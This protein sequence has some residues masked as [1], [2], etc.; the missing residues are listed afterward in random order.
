MQL[1]NRIEE[2]KNH[3][4]HAK[5]SSAGDRLVFLS[6]K[7]NLSKF[8]SSKCLANLF[9]VLHWNWLDFSFNLLRMLSALLRSVHRVFF[10]LSSSLEYIFCSPFRSLAR[11]LRFFSRFCIGTT[12]KSS[13]I[14]LIINVD[15]VC[16]CMHICDNFYFVVHHFTSRH[17][18]QWWCCRHFVQQSRKILFGIRK[19]RTRWKWFKYFMEFY[20]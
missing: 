6:S 16:A 14:V 11:S 8:L 20:R 7:T 17:L 15:I 5:L 1:W 4:T 9:V 13:E 12:Y 3:Q 19:L 18:P 2:E 10:F